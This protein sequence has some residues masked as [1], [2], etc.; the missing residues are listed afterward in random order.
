MPIWKFVFDM[1]AMRMYFGTPILLIVP[2]G[3][4]VMDTVTDD[5]HK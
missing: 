3:V 5:G 4:V 1:M 2:Q